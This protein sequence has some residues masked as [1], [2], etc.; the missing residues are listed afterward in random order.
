MYLSSLVLHVVKLSPDAGSLLLTIC[1]LQ[2]PSHLITDSVY[3][4]YI[5]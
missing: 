1:I 4:I 2:G 3:W 5:Y